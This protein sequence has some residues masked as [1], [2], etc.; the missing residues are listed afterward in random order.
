ME[1]C[2]FGDVALS[3]LR[4]PTLATAALRPYKFHTDPATDFIYLLPLALAP[5]VLGNHSAD[6]IHPSTHE[7]PADNEIKV[8]L[9]PFL[10]P[11]TRDDLAGKIYA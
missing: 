9:D 7:F 2:E 11:T 6:T 8:R 5:L 4:R 10:A 3:V 1:I